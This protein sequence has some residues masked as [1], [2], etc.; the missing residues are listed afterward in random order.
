MPQVFFRTA[1]VAVSINL[2]EDKAMAIGGDNF[3]AHF[4][5][6]NPLPIYEG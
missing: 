1:D 5:M 6:L 2:P 4:T 3:T